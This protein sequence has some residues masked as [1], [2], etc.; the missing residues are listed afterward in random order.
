MEINNCSD[1]Y[2]EYLRSPKWQH[3]RERVLL[4][5]NYTCVICGGRATHVHHIR[6]AH[7]FNEE[8]HLEDLCCLCEKDH[9]RIHLYFKFVDELKEYYAKKKHEENLR[10]GYY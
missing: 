8:N 5:D 9:D 3:I 7:R 1:Q 2:K 10:K 6:G 4:R